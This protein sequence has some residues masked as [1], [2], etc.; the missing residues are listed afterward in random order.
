MKRTFAATIF[1][2]LTIIV[3]GSAFAASFERQMERLT[4][5]SINRLNMQES[6]NR[7]LIN[8]RR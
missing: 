3:A 2:A 1:A 5:A 7:A 8:N 4:N 6:N